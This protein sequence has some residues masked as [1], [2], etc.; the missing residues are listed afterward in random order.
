[1]EVTLVYKGSAVLSAAVRACV[2]KQSKD[3][4]YFAQVSAKLSMAQFMC[5]AD[6]NLT[7]RMCKVQM[8]LEHP[9]RM[10]CRAQYCIVPI[11]RFPEDGY[12]CGFVAREDR[13]CFI[14]NFKEFVILEEPF[15]TQ[16]K[17]VH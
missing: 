8:S 6:M 5:W 15:T 17:I 12:F 10:M 3:H 1:M 9:P 11:T 13:E 4:P 14:R 16:F 7:K 2:E